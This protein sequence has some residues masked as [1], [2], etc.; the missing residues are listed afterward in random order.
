M[1]QE[2][3]FVD[4]DNSLGTPGAEI[5]DGAAL[6]MLLRS[7]KIKV[8]GISSVNGNVSAELA[9]QNTSRILSHLDKTQIPIG[10]GVSLP[11]IEDPGWFLPWQAGYGPTPPWQCNKIHPN[12]VN[13]MIDVIRSAP[14]QVT[15][16]AIGPL[17]NLAL[18]IRLAP[19]I[20]K[21]VRNVIVMGGSFGE[22]APVA[23][24][25]IRSD[26][27]AAQIV[28][29]AGWPLL[30]LGL[31]I[32]R[33]ITFS[34]KDFLSLVDGNLAVNLLKSQASGWI[35]R[36]EKM[37]WDKN[38]CALHD[39]VAVAALLERNLFSFRAMNVKV[40][41]ANT[42]QRGTIG[43]EAIREGSEARCINVAV[44]VCEA[45]CRELIWSLLNR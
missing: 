36:V 43:F 11:L 29:N 17:T 13:L 14:E 26:P 32:T 30:L 25:N 23:E 18:A 5:D 2:L 6:I 4:T 3:V 41:L 24:F 33:H 28:F 40:E 31:N 39:A 20:I 34:H 27:E 16:L 7:E 22:D 45:Q 38:Q 9:A 37:G 12:G 35:E 15:I 21:K 44:K 8:L 10:C 19:D 1:N 42:E